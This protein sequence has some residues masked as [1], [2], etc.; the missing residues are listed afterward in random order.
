M[1]RE[2]MNMNT[3]RCLVWGL[4]VLGLIVAVTPS[5]AVGTRPGVD[6]TVDD[7]G[8]KIILD[9][10]FGAYAA[11][12]VRLDGV[13]Y[14][15]VML[16]KESQVCEKGAPDVANVCRSVVISDDAKME[17]NVSAQEYYDVKDIDVVSSKGHFPRTINPDDVP[18]TFGAAYTTDAFYPGE[19]AVLGEPYILRDCRGAVVT[20]NP[21]Q[22]N[23]VTRVLR[24]YT[25]V[26]VEVAVV[27]EGQINVLTH[28]PETLSKAFDDLYQGHFLNYSR[29][30]FG[31]RYD[32]LSEEGDM[33]VI[34]HDPWASNVAP[35]VDHKNATGLSTTMV[36]VSV[37]G[38]NSVSIKNYIQDEYASG[39]LAFVLL[40]GDGA[41]VD[42]PYASGGSSDPSYALLAGSDSYPDIFVGRFSAET[43]AQVDTQVQ[44][45]ISYEQ[46]PAT[47][48]D[49]FWRGMGVASNQG[50]GDDGE[51][52]NEHMDNI[53]DDLLA[54]GYT[55][56]DQIYDPS[57]TSSQVTSALNAGRGIVNYTGHGSTTSWGSTG[58]S[59]SHVNALQNDNMLP[60]IISVACVNGQFDG[61]TCFGEAWLRATHNG[62]P[63]GAIGAYMSSINQSWN[64]PM[65]GQD[66]VVDRFVDPAE[67]YSTFGALCFAG[68]CQMMD[69]YGSDGVNM[70]N[71]WIVFGDPSV[72]VIN[73]FRAV[74]ISFPDGLPELLLP[75]EPTDITVR[76]DQGTEGCVPGSGELHYR[77]DGGE[78]VALQLEPLGDDLYLATLP[79]PTCDSVPEF[80]FSA[81]G[82]ESGTIYE[83]ADAPTEI[84]IAGVGEKV[85]VMS[86]DF[87]TGLDWAV[88]N[89]SLTDG[90]WERGTPVGG[91]LRG[92]PAADYDGSGQCYLGRRW[93]TRQADL[94]DAR[95]CRRR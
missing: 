44:R 3:Y 46:M 21:F 60:F 1:T 53:R 9:Y 85:I 83:P 47:Q 59:V 16:G 84:L 39:D 64:S 71:T 73:T 28:R 48:Q 80:Y 76:I 57:G 92:D 61:Y 45:T 67:P 94:A 14:V 78:F 27:G 18:Y 42:T 34:Y 32:P 24:V 95:S 4:A 5:L 38:N 37:I 56:V 52:D 41:Q 65:C 86:D 49:W 35:L 63:T 74:S 13:E 10:S 68:S 75:N 36:A 12:S 19:L 6:V 25:S 70:F 26:T 22:Y 2:G 43:A 87:E 17:I 31:Q 82:A 20:I 51:Y 23:P 69:E 33:L 90:E 11:E 55:E 7:Q 66:E 58:F 81:E 77:Y 91:G 29:E 54:A 40:V 72:Q 8:D 89:V 30:K 88:E 15:K 50:P 62:E 93:R 79:A